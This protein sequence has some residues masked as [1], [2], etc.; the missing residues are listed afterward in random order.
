MTDYESI[1]KIITERD[2]SPEIEK[3]LEEVKTTESKDL[4]FK[5]AQLRLTQEKLK[6]TL[7]DY[8]SKRLVREI[9]LEKPIFSNPEYKNAETRKTMAMDVKLADSDYQTIYTQ[10]K[11]CETAIN[12]LGVIINALEMQFKIIYRI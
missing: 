11:E 4:P 6:A 10:I 7:S 2:F 12:I 8:Q 9:E 3:L 1:G 5:I